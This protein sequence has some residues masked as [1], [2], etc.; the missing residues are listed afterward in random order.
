MVSA[1]KRIATSKKSLLVTVGLLGDAAAVWG[2]GAP[3]EQ[4]TTGFMLYWNAGIGLLTAAQAA[5]DMV[6]GS[7]S[8]GTGS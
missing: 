1:I 8:D 5:I 2:F 6:H 4:L 3:A 7:P